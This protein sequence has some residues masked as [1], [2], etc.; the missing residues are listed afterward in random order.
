MGLYCAL[1]VFAYTKL[2]GKE[3]NDKNSIKEIYIMQ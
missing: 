2:E 3:L 1:R